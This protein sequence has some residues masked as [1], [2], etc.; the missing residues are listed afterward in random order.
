MMVVAGIGAAAG[1]ALCMAVLLMPA[2]TRSAAMFVLAVGAA[3][4]GALTAVVAWYAVRHTRLAAGLSR[5]AR[6]AAVVGVAVHE[7]DGLDG[8]LVAGLRRPRIYCG[9]QLTSQLEPDELRAVLLHEAFHQLDLAPAR[10]VVLQAVAPFIRWRPAGRAWLASRVARLEIAADRHALAR[11]VGRPALAR[12]LLK[13]AP[14]RREFSAGFASALEL[15]L[16][17]LLDDREAPVATDRAQW[18]L[19]LAAATALCLAIVAAT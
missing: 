5:L 3:L 14:T 8:A 15:R 12:A 2:Q 17:A 4:A 11:G 1:I 13:L 18:V 7:L 6:P 10:L 19:W 16:Q 9:P